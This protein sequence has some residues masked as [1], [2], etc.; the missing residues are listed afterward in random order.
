MRFPRKFFQNLWTS[1]LS[2]HLKNDAFWISKVVLW[3]RK[4]QVSLHNINSWISLILEIP[5][6]IFYRR[7][8]CN[9]IHF[10]VVA[11]LE[12]NNF[13]RFQ[14]TCTKMDLRDFDIFLFFHWI[15]WFLCA[16]LDTIL[17]ANKSCKTKWSCFAKSERAFVILTTFCVK[18]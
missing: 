17:F 14:N 5:A 16:L 8:L 2:A 9:H 7:N 3:T 12:S 1:S 6:C 4:T 13:L 18:K 11:I 15:L 10:F